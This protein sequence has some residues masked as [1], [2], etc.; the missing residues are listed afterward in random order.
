MLEHPVSS[1]VISFTVSRRTIPLLR[2]HVLASRRNV[3][4]F[5][6]V[7]LLVVI[8]IIG[9]LVA[10][11]LPAVQSAREA[12]R[13]TA[14]NNKFAQIGKAAH[15]YHAAIGQ[16]PSG[17]NMWDWRDPCTTPDGNP[18]DGIDRSWSWG[19]FMLPY[20]EQQALY[21][22]F[23]KDFLTYHEV[24]ENY[25]AAAR[26]VPVFL[27]PSDPQ[28]E[29]LVY[30]C[31]TKSNG[32]SYLEDMA[33][34]NMAGVADT[35][36]WQCT[37]PGRGF[38]NGWPNPKGDGTLFNRSQVA[39]KHITDGTSHTLFVGEVIGLG[40]GSYEA[41]FWAS[42][43][44]LHTANGINQST[45]PYTPSEAGFASL[46]PGGCFFVLADSSVQFLSETIDQHVLLA[47]TTRAGEEIVDEAL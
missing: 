9:V 4:G 37:P 28:G 11:L 5:T 43:N 13:R 44:I 27:C 8:A 38:P 34:T 3:C 33:K 15:S 41:H 19:M 47:M 30:C 7:E 39:T 1:T 40:E 36:S 2:R 12:A 35:E 10:L 23:N 46:H 17:V 24:P 14:C 21:D 25:A 29:E 26:F 18:G 22:E 20:M 6:L 45:H 32:S 31:S 42:W 16:F